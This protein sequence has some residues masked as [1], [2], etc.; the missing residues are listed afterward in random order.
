M[1]HHYSKPY[2]TRQYGHKQKFP[3]MI[4]YSLYRKWD[5]DYRTKYHCDTIYQYQAI[6]PT[7]EE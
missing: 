7:K 4:F 6:I 3:F 5:K 1:Q 2:R